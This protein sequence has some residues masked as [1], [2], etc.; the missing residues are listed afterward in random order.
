MRRDHAEQIWSAISKFVPAKSRD[1]WSER[2]IEEICNVS[3]KTGP[4]PKPDPKADF[5]NDARAWARRHLETNENVCVQ[6]VIDYFGIP[7]HIPPDAVGGIFKHRDFTKVGSKKIIMPKGHRPR[8]KT[9]NTYVATG[10][11]RDPSLIVTWD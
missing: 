10:S 3:L 2:F 9:V 1:M 4:E 8:S 11:H 6:D 5:I 7:N